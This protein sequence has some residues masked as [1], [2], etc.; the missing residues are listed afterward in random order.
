MHQFQLLKCLFNVQHFQENIF[1][2]VRGIIN[3]F[4]EFISSNLLEQ[5]CTLKRR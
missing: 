4:P 3:G 2:E 1:A 5:Q